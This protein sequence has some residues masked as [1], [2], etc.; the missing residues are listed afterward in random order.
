V[1]EQSLAAS[2]HQ[3][4]LSQLLE[5]PG[6]VGDGQAGLCRERLDGALA[7]GEHFEDF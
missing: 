7:L 6:R 2:Q 5:M 3:L 1:D 4:C